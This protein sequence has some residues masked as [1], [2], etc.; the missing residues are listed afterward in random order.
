LAELLR[1][2]GEVR[3]YPLIDTTYVRYP[4]LDELRRWLDGRGHPSEV[5]RVGY[6][7]QRGADQVL[8][9]APRA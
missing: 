2:G 3:V 8:V 6:E 4:H 5:R 7:F 9:V 1:V